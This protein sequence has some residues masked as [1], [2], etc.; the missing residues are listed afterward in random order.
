MPAKGGAPMRDSDAEGSP[1]RSPQQAARKVE[2]VGGCG[3]EGV[4]VPSLLTL[5]PLV[6]D[7]A[8]FL[9][10]LQTDPVFAAHA[11]WRVTNAISDGEGWWRESIADPDPLLLRLLATTVDGP[12]GYVDLHGRDAHVRELGYAIGPSPRWGHGLATEAARA[13]I[14]WGFERLHLDRIWA[15][16]VEANIAS[17][18]VLEKV[19]MHPIGRGADESFLGVPS[20]YKRYEILR[21]S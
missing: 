19:G 3:C 15:E 8:S 21:P 7:D 6:A 18:R 13:G 11:G 17:V 16:A 14:E 12:V 5:R 2:E 10:S 9:A 1:S 20:H 4:D